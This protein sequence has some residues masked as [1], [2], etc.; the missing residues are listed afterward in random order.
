MI[1]R[2]WAESE[3]VRWMQHVL[4][5][6]RHWTGADLM[7]RTGPPDQQAQQVYEASFILVSHDNQDDPILNYG[8]RAA[9]LLWE[10][11]WQDFCRTPSRLTAESAGQLERARMLA[12]A[13]TRGYVA[14]Y[15]GVRISHTGRRFFI[16]Q[17]CVWN[18][19]DA[20]LKKIGQAA[21]FSRWRWLDAE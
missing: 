8:N 11:T 3:R 21:S 13:K 16:E 9:L 6:F 1:D 10:M 17:A 4:G 2:W 7:E 18:V 5:S 15:Q 19:L 14:D 12:N 20:E